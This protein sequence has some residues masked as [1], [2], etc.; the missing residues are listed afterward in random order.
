MTEE[1]PSAFGTQPLLRVE[2]LNVW[3]GAGGGQTGY[4]FRFWMTFLSI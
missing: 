3:Y 4:A 1:L 2:K